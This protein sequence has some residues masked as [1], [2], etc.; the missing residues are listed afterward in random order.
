M[1]TPEAPSTEPNEDRSRS[2][3]PRVLLAEDDSELR[4]LIARAL[5]KCGIEVVEVTD[6]NAL[7][8][9]VG[10]LMK[11]DRTLSELSLIVSD[12][13]MPGWSGLNVLAGLTY[14]SSTVPM[15]LITAFGDEQTHAIAKNLGALAVVDKP[16]NMDDLCQV[17]LEALK[18]PRHDGP[19]KPGAAPT[20]RQ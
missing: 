11:R 19:S 13:R 10:D 14:F 1:T 7:M 9:L 17:V 8:D 20:P 16:F 12:I 15:V 18:R 5:R 4:W 6:G 3:K 2:S